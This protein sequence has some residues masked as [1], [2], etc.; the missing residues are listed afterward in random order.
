MEL[1][2]VDAL[3]PQPLQRAVARLAQVLGASVVD[4]PVGARAHLS[5]LGRDHEPIRVRVQGFRDQLLA[6]VG[7]V[8][9]GR[10]DQRHA[11]LNRAP[12]HRQRLI[13]V[14]RRPPDALTGDPHRA[15]PKPVHLEATDPD[16][17][18]GH[19]RTLQRPYGT[20]DVLGANLRLSERTMTGETM[21]S[22][23]PPGASVERAL[24]GSAA[25]SSP[26]GPAA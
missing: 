21:T 3:E 16:R 6:D 24:R 18:G 20:R 1:V 8:R 13:V 23:S 12:K 22:E 11:E 25:R 17:P 4:P 19:R 26:N 2:E 14:T 7:P 9:V 5:A 10:V 15:K